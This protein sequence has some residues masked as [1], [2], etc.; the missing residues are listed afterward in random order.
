MGWAKTG[1]TVFRRREGVGHV[2][3]LSETVGVS[4]AFVG[5]LNG[6]VD[7]P[8]IDGGESRFVG[9]D[10]AP[11]LLSVQTRDRQESAGRA[12]RHLGARTSGICQRW[13]G[14]ASCCFTP[15]A[16]KGFGCFG[17]E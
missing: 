5:W 7:P 3:I 8:A 16:S 9:S 14:S 2:F 11:G 10:F 17:E 13:N 4:H 1:Q 12:A 6:S 15:D